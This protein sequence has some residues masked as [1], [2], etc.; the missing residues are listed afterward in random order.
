MPVEIVCVI[1]KSGSMEAT[2]SD[3]IGGFNSMLADQKKQNPDAR[4]TVTLF[5]TSYNIVHSGKPLAE[6]PELTPET[7]QPGG[8]T[9]LLDAFGRTIDEVGERLAKTP[10]GE[11]P[12][13]VIFGLLTDGYE[14]SSKEYSKPQ[15]QEKVK[16]QE[17]NYS[18]QFIYLGANQDAM[19]EGASMGL[20]VAANYLGTKQGTQAAYRATSQAVSCAASGEQ[21]TG[22]KLQHLVREEEQR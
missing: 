18:W 2:K 13:R 11:R 21:L 4:M 9:A 8:M 19:A 5:D 12:D 22:V 17:E 6:V 1:D 10:E 20:H 7:Y 3:A 15:I 14:N 16:H